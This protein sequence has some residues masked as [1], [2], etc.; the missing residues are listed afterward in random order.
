MAIPKEWPT[1]GFPA[2]LRQRRQRFPAPGTLDVSFFL[3]RIAI[4][5]GQ[6][7][8]GFATSKICSKS[9]SKIL[10]D[11]RFRSTIRATRRGSRL[12][13]V[14]ERYVMKNRSGHLWF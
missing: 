1:L 2:L 10:E 8:K 5:C 6:H 14:K 7:S 13:D 4:S 3:Q 11:R 12:R 9:L